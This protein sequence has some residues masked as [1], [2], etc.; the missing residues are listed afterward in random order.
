MPAALLALLLKKRVII[1]TH[2]MIV[3]SKHPIAPALP[4]GVPPSPP[5]ATLNDTDVEF[6]YL[7]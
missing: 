6:L 4:N 3:K 2:G 5:L 7:A 1:Q